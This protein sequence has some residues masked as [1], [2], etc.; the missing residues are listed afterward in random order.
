MPTEQPNV[1][2]SD[3]EDPLVKLRGMARYMRVEHV[4]ACDGC[5]AYLD[6]ACD[7]WELERRNRPMPAPDPRS[8]TEAEAAA[9]PPW[10]PPAPRHRPAS[11]SAS[12]TAPAP[13]SC[14]ERAPAPRRP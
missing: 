13:W 1:S 12:L 3:A 11:P 7:A 5:A 14:N 9:C 4:K 8:V 2:K 10:E 6:A